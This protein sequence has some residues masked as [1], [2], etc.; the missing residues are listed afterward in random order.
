MFLP[1]ILRILCL[2]QSKS[3]YKHSGEIHLVHVDMRKGYSFLDYI[4]GGTEIAAT[5]SIG[6]SIFKAALA[7]LQPSRD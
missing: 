7:K 5:I 1:K 6:K 2:P 3:S 4:R